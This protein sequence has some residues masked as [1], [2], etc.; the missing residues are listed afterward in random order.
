VKVVESCQLGEESAAAWAVPSALSWDVGS[1]LGLAAEL[2][3][4]SAGRMGFELEVEWARV[5][6]SRLGAGSAVVKGEGSGRKSAE[7]LAVGKGAA[8]ELARGLGLER[9]TGLARAEGREV[10][11]VKN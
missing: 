11:W 6:A 1:G 4:G 9:V 8:K 7:R 5:K 3:A 2:E 10:G